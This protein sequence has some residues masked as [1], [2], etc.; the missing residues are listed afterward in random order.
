MLM[1]YACRAGSMPTSTTT[2]H[3]RLFKNG[4]SQA[5]RIPREFELPGREAI[6]RQE[7]DGRLIPRACQDGQAVELAGVVGGT[8]RGKC[9]ACDRRS[10][11]RRQ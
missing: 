2:R 4:R 3:V 10:C 7:A 11:S 9:L 6:M 1:A 8:E 5:V